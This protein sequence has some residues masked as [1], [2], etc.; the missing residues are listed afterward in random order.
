VDNSNFVVMG[1]EMA[2]KAANIP[3]PKLAYFC[4][5]GI[6]FGSGLGSSS[7]AIVSGLLAGLV[8]TGQKLKCHGAEE[9]LQIAA[10]VEGEHACT[11]V[12]KPRPCVLAFAC[13]A[14]VRFVLLF[15]RVSSSSLLPSPQP[16]PPPPPSSTF[17][18]IATMSCA[19]AT[20]HCVCATAALCNT[21]AISAG[22]TDNLAPCIYGGAQIGVFD[23]DQKRWDTHAV[24]VPNGLR[25]VIFTPDTPMSTE[26]ARSILPKMIDR[27]DAVFNLGRTALL[28][29]AF[30]T[31]RLELL[32]TATEDRLHQPCVPPP[33]HPAILLLLSSSRMYTQPPLI[34]ITVWQD[35][36]RAPSSLL[37]YAFHRYRGAANVMPALFPCVNAALAAGAVG[38]FLSG[39]G[40]SIMAITAGGA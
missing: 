12:R 29:L 4:Q 24:P 37:R 22:H 1:V 9:L 30:C 31:D 17:G 5:N 38:A 15:S 21:S 28:V 40:S 16:W 3:M 32:K 25:C 33:P 23:T 13:F 6:P 36:S 14:C 8:L 26:F 7:A 27:K 19:W 10:T 18:I 34:C 35:N 39:A 11:R 20:P 2:F